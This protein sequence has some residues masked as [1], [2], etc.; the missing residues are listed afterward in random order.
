[1]NNESKN[2]VPEWDERILLS[3][4]GIITSLIM[5]K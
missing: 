1:M 3:K 5:I 2:Q 4:S